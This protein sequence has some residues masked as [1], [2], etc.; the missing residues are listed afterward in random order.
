[1]FGVKFESNRERERERAAKT[2]RQPS[3]EE[4]VKLETL[5]IQTLNI[6]LKGCVTLKRHIA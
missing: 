5:H 4:A 1:M 3:D 6:R 2:D